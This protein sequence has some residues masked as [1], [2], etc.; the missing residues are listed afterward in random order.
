ML[1]SGNVWGMKKENYGENAYFFQNCLFLR[2]LY[3]YMLFFIRNL[4]GGIEAEVSFFFKD[5]EPHSSL[6]VPYLFLIFKLFLVFFS[7]S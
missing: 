3:L 4:C 2:F 7:V 5:C 6:L 1:N